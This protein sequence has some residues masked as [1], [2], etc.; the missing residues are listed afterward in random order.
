MLCFL[1]LYMMT[2]GMHYSLKMDFLLDYFERLQ[3]L[4]AKLEKTKYFAFDL[5][6]NDEILQYRN[7]ILGILGLKK[8]KAWA[9][10]TL[11]KQMSCLRMKKCSLL[12]KYHGHILV[13]CLL[14]EV[15]CKT[16]EYQSSN[17]EHSGRIH[18][19][20]LS[21]FA[22]FSHFVLFHV[23]KRNKI[24]NIWKKEM[25]KLRWR[26]CS[27]CT[28]ALVIQKQD[29]EYPAIYKEPLFHL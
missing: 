21:I 15:N 7:V 5:S 19:V 10:L 14:S 17:Q 1:V 3:I 6:W 27:K 8:I 12:D 22:A 9:A 4:L 25:E 11:K 13:S 29:T 28:P 23:K 2:R 26:D 20:P 16:G 18:W 24:T